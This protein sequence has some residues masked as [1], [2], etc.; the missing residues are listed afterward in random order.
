MPLVV[1]ADVPHRKMECAN[2][3]GQNILLIMNQLLNKSNSKSVNQVSCSSKSPLYALSI[4]SWLN[5][6]ID[7]AFACIISWLGS[8]WGYFIYEHIDIKESAVA[9]GEVPNIG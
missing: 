5:A 4:H 3:A 6:M 7:S 2:A 9:V 8:T 1:T